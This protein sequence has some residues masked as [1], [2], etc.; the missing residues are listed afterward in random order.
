VRPDAIGMIDEVLLLIVRMKIGGRIDPA[1][2][3]VRAGLN[4]GWEPRILLSLCR[5]ACIIPS[6]VY[7]VARETYRK[8]K[9]GWLGKPL[10][11]TFHTRIED[12]NLRR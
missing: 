8:V 7:N 1:Y 3:I 5:L 11:P 12:D 9:Y 6:G 10:P 4:A 2:H